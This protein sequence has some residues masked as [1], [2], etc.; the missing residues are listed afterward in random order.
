MPNFT[1]ASLKDKIRG[2]WAFILAASSAPIAFIISGPCASTGCAGCPLGGSCVIS[3]P[4]VFSGMLVVRFKDRVR[5]K[6]YSAIDRLP[7]LKRA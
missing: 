7:K 5:A 2:G 1:L 3:L 6:I 4:L